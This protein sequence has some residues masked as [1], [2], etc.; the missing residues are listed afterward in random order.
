MLDLFT[1]LADLVAFNLLGLSQNSKLGDAVHFFVEDTTKI[2]FLLTVMI[3]IIGFL[4]VGL[5][6]EKVR[7][8]L[9]GRNRFLGYVLASLLGAVTPFC[10]CLLYT[11]PSPRDS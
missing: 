6:A 7:I 3:F 8:W 9:K 10:S 5:D 1:G 11:S 2:F 4:R